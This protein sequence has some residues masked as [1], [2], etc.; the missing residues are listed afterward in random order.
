M[1]EVTGRVVKEIPASIIRHTVTRASMIEQI[2]VAAY[3][4]VSTDR[5]EQED[6]F[7]R[8]VDYYTR[9]INSKAEW[10]F[11]GIY[12][13]PGITGTRTDKRKEFQ[14]MMNDAKEGKIKKILCKSIARFARN[15][16]DALQSIRVLKEIGVSVYFETQNIDTLSP[17]GEVLITI[18]AAMAEQESRTISTNIKW[19]YQKKFQNGEVQLNY[20]RF[21]GYTKGKNGELEIVPEE[22]SIVKRIYREFLFGRSSAQIAKELTE[23]G[24]PTPSMKPDKNGNMPQKKMSGK[25]F[26]S[27]VRSILKNEKYM[28]CAIL[29]K[30]YKGRTLTFEFRVGVKESI[31]I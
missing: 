27:T 6:S 3:A 1:A 13:D 8:Q 24:I 26:P 21:L 29:G 16:V 31:T 2:P 5:V 19:A 12:A 9:Y 30:T 25:W 23:D 10:K 4:R 28:G 15:T 11:V 22:A 17:G 7:E 20:S 14:R 18:L